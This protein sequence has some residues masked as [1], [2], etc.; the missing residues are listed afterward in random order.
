MVWCKN[1]SPL[2]SFK[3]FQ[4]FDFEMAEQLEN[5]EH[6]NIQK[7]CYQKWDDV[8]DMFFHMGFYLKRKMAIGGSI[9]QMKYQNCVASTSVKR[10]LN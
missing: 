2:Y 8:K 5:N 6:G 1:H 7:G 9:S 3:I 10:L 4:T